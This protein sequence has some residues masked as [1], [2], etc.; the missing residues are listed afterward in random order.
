VTR[1]VAGPLEVLFTGVSFIGKI[2]DVLSKSGVGTVQFRSSETSSLTV[3]DC[4]DKVFSSL[5]PNLVV[6]D[7][8]WPESVIISGIKADVLNVEIKNQK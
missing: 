5:S 2:A 3:Q 4:L 7:S 6:V 1:V 8:F